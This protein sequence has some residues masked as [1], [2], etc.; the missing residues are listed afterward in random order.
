MPWLEHQ[1]NCNPS[2]SSRHSEQHQRQGRTKDL[3]TRW[4]SGVVDILRNANRGNRASARLSEWVS[5]GGNVFVGQTE[6]KLCARF[7]KM[8]VRMTYFIFMYG[9][10]W[11][12]DTMDGFAFSDG[13]KNSIRGTK[14]RKKEFLRG[15]WY[16]IWDLFAICHETSCAEQSGAGHNCTRKKGLNLETTQKKCEI[17]LN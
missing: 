9:R 14:P 8:L 16:E 6:G 15:R 3:G 11:M 12:P 1:L 5:W 13:H 17:C 7:I 4:R 10:W 2:L